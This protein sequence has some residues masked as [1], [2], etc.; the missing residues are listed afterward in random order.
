MVGG[1]CVLLHAPH[2]SGVVSMACSVITSQRKYA[3]A[4]CYKEGAARK[5]GIVLVECRSDSNIL[6]LALAN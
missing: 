1:G 2:S 6:F 5:N 3:Q 4:T